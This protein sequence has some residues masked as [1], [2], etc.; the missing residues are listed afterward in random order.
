MFRRSMN[1]PGEKPCRIIWFNIYINM[2]LIR[3][4][5]ICPNETYFKSLTYKNLSDAFAIQNGLKL[6]DL[7]SLLF[8][9]SLAFDI[10][11]AR[12]IEQ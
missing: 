6:D 3:Q 1:Q 9:F 2:K 12:E 5:K 11:N 8:S 7:S 10:R 4:I